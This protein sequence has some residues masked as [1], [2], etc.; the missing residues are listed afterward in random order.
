MKNDS[1][2]RQ[3][4]PLQVVP[5]NPRHHT[6]PTV[7][8]ATLQINIRHKLDQVTQGMRFAVSRNSSPLRETAS[9]RMQRSD[10]G[11]PDPVVKHHPPHPLSSR[12][13]AYCLHTRSASTSENRRKKD[14]GLPFA[15][16][17]T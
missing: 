9:K 8:Q 4:S 3:T 14:K 12:R 7:S 10:Q 5:H 13:R 2:T 15:G 16:T 6:K 1:L 11:D 17:S